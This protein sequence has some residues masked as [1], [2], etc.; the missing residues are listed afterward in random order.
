[1]TDSLLTFADL[2]M[3]FEASPDRMRTL[4][5]RPDFP[6]SVIL[7]VQGL[8]RRWFRDEVVSYILQLE[9]EPTALRQVA[10]VRRG[11]RSEPKRIAGSR[12]ARHPRAAGRQGTTNIETVS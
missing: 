9:R 3:S 2:C 11:P 7:S 5:R 6:E 4:L 8:S 1:M 10:T 12:R